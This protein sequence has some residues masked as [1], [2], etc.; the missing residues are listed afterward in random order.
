M[1]LS[2][3]FWG[4]LTRVHL[5]LCAWGCQVLICVIVTGENLQQEAG[6]GP[7]RIPPSLAPAKLQ[8]P[9]QFGCHIPCDLGLAPQ[10]TED[11]ET[12]GEKMTFPE[13]QCESVAAGTVSALF[14]AL[15]LAPY[16]APGKQAS[17]GA[18]EIAVAQ[19]MSTVKECIP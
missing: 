2:L 10:F 7:D 16:A 12:Q 5:C 6:P 18:Q 13:S 3:S 1:G 14:S 17:W 15:T 11:T 19:V 4:I 9:E 8:T